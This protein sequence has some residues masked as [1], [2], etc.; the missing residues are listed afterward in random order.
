MHILLST[1]LFI[2]IA[3]I[4]GLFTLKIIEL[5]QRVIFCSIWR[6][7]YDDT[8]LRIV[9]R[10]IKKI[11]LLS[12]T[13]KV[14]DSIPHVIGAFRSVCAIV[15]RLVENRPIRLTGLAYTGGVQT[16]ARVSRFLREVSKSKERDTVAG[17]EQRIDS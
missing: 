13:V 5:H 8:L 17:Q 2:G 12:S 3:G 1:L 11:E 7:K 15:I 9:V 16:S 4:C 6:K 10:S 14:P